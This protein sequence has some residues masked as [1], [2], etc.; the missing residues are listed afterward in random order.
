M[1][2]AVIAGI[3]WLLPNDAAGLLFIVGTALGIAAVLAAVVLVPAICWLLVR[4]KLAARRKKHAQ[5]SFLKKVYVATREHLSTLCAEEL[6][7]TGWNAQVVPQAGHRDVDVIAEKNGVRVVLWCKL[8]AGPVSD[9][10]V[11]EAAA[12]RAHERADYGLVIADNRYTAA[13]ERVA[14]K[15][16]VLLLY[17]RDLRNLDKILLSP[18]GAPSVPVLTTKGP[19]RA[20]GAASALAFK[21][22]RARWGALVARDPQLRA[23][24]EK[25]RPLGV[26]WVDRFAASYIA[27]N[28]RS[29][30]PTLVTE[31]IA[32]ARKEFEQREAARRRRAL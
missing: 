28:D 19:E 8:Y 26:R 4:K 1:G 3:N 14:A 10:A 11:E 15:N 12:G 2:L 16:G 17:H 5:Q 24:A 23:V 7:R 18:S 27:A 31:I 13:V 9:Q 6:R 21:F 30:L 32:H 22:D 29:R 25:L 20:H